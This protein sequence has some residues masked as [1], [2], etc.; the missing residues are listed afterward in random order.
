[1]STCLHRCGSYSQMVQVL[2]QYMETLNKTAHTL[3]QR[4]TQLS[5]T[6]AT[7]SQ[8]CEKCI[9]NFEIC[10]TSNNNIYLYARGGQWEIPCYNLCRHTLINKV[11][12]YMFLYH[13]PTLT[14][15]FLRSN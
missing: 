13:V 1:M 2:Y 5:I 12:T 14:Y 4:V 15:E 6:M 9:L 11:A 7:S 8:C 3:S 10:K